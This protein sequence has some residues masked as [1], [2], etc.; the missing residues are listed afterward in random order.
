MEADG[1]FV[2]GALREGGR[3]HSWLLR[4]NPEG[5]TG[6]H[7]PGRLFHLP[8]HGIP[9]LVP[10]DEP[11]LGP[12]GPG[13]VAGEFAGYE[14][15]ASLASALEDLDQVEDVEGGLFERRVIPVVLDSGHRFG[16]WVYVFPPDRLTRLE[17]EGVELP[18]GDWKEYLGE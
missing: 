12:P 11:P 2:Y 5:L 14:D 18:T 7:V 9:A 15:E 1:V 4:T 13:W 10:G 3:A 17:R 16:A 6:A 8:A